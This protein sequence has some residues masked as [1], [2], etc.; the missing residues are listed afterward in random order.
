MPTEKLKI[1][2][3]T[4]PFTQINTPYPASAY[5]KGFLNTLEIPSAQLD[6]GLN[7]ILNLFSKKGLQ[8][9]FAQVDTGKDWSEH[10]QFVLAHQQEY[11]NTISEVVLFLQGKRDSL[12][13][14]ISNGNFLPQPPS[15]RT[16]QEELEWAFGIMGNRDKARHLCTLYLEDLSRFIVETT[17]ADFGFSRYAEQIGRYARE[18]DELDLALKQPIGFTQQII[19]DELEDFIQKEKPHLIA[20]SIPFPGNLFSGFLCAAYIKEKHPEIKTALGGGFVNT[21]LRSLS[22]P[23]VFNYFDAVC[24]DDGEAPL[25]SVYE[26]ISGRSTSD[27]LR[28]TFIRVNNQ[29]NYIHSDFYS[30]Y[31]QKEVGTP[32]YS[33]L[34][35][36]EYLSVIEVTNPM[37]SLW[38][39]G[40]WNKLTLAHG[41]YWGKCTFCDTSLDYIRVYEFTTAKMIV[42]RMEE[43]IHATGETGFH[44]VDEAAPP[45]LM[46]E[47]ALEIIRRK[48]VVSW[49]TNIRFEKSFHSDLCR[50]LAASGC[51]AVSGGLEVASDR[52][53][54]LIDKGVSV[55]QVSQVCANFTDAGIMVHAYLMYGYPT[56]TAQETIDSLEVVRQLFE[57]G[58]IQSGFWHRFALTVHSPV[59]QQPDKFGIRILPDQ[60]GRFANNDLDY[61]ETSG[62]DHALFSEGLKTSL[63]NY[64]HGKGFE[65]PLSK[66]FNHKT[67]KTSLP[68]N[69][70]ENYLSNI[71]FREIKDEQQMIWTGHYHLGESKIRKGKKYSSWELFGSN[72]NVHLELEEA[73]SQFLN[74][75]LHN[76]VICGSVKTFKK[77]FEENTG[78]NPSLF[79]HSETMDVFRSAGLLLV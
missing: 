39:D 20:F 58:L 29:V 41:C 3:I 55:E 8:S 56:Q 5:L 60:H 57:N 27:H 34:R 7:V 31:K 66:W 6:L 2:L 9:L 46:K 21:E 48:L 24:L 67:P 25:L 59:A 23:R 18:F 50:L 42:D 19:L 61:E 71:P 78:Q 13:R 44:F 74:T 79:L 40:R 15:Q 49:W 1:G 63:Y 26:W 76:K 33:G 75:W 37:H 28:R 53:L 10:A 30:D 73:T 64:L 32:D 65:L 36:D 69:L 45:A 68:K 62:C 35:T 77:S 14:R 43:L 16:H 38:N 22:E 70:I 47:L 17:D 12:A 51:I 72:E 54:Q 11:I 52:L 4:P